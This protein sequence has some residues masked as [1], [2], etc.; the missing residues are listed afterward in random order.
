MYLEKITNKGFNILKSEK[1]P[2]HTLCPAI[3]LDNNKFDLSIAT[4]GD[5]GQPQTIFQILNYIYNYGYKIQNYCYPT[6]LEPKGI[7]VFHHGFSEYCGR[8]AHAG[9]LISE[10]GYHFYAMDMR[11]HG[12][13]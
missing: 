12:K 3:V 5:H 10:K 4:P 9:K 8:F 6:E 2:F 11:G 7:I 1:S 13:S